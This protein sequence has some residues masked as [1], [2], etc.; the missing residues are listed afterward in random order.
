MPITLRTQHNCHHLVFKK[1]CC[2]CLL[3]YRYAM[4]RKRIFT[5]FWYSNLAV[6]IDFPIGTQSNA[7]AVTLCIFFLRFASFIN[8]PISTQSSARALRFDFTL[9]FL[10]DFPIGTQCNAQIFSILFLCS[11]LAVFID[12][13]ISTQSSATAVTSH[14]FSI[15]LLSLIGFPISTQRNVQEKK[16]KQSEIS[17]ASRQGVAARRRG[18]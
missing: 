13:H 15:F 11:K 7:T 1:C 4:Q 14:I 12:F 9:L 18:K 17:Q 10:I 3:P 5:I 2:F 6:L 16:D 8:F